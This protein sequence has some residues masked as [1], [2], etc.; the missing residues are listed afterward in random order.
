MAPELERD[1][2]DGEALQLTAVGRDTVV[3]TCRVLVEA[4]TA[5]FGRLVVAGARGRGIG[6]ALLA[7]GERAA[8]QAGADRVVLHAQAHATRLY[9]AQGLAPVGEVFQEAG[10]EHVRMEKPLA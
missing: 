7:A 1:G 4:G 8:R 10:I 6:A 5:K 9:D 2:H 3:V